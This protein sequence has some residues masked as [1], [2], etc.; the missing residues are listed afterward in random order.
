VWNQSLCELGSEINKN[1]MFQAVMRA[2]TITIQS[3]KHLGQMS[4][5]WHDRKDT[6]QDLTLL[7]TQCKQHIQDTLH[8]TH[9][10]AS[11]AQRT[12]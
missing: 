7:K 1:F 10:M 11:Q 8:I 4:N 3:G 2:H 5:G 9:I 12:R 6:K